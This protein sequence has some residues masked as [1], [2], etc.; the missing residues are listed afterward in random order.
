M[1][2]AKSTAMQILLAWRDNKWVVLRNAVEVGAYV[3]KAHAL[4]MARRLATEAAELGLECYMLIRER[5]GRWEERP[6]PK[7]RR[8]SCD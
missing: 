5:D 3:Y 2:V 8:G 7:P 4:E 6:C 1:S